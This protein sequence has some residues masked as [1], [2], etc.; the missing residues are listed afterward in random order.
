MTYTGGFGIRLNSKDIYCVFAENQS[1][2]GHQHGS[3]YSRLLKFLSK[4]DRLSVVIIIARATTAYSFLTLKLEL[5]LVDELSIFGKLI[6]VLDFRLCITEFHVIEP[7]FTCV[8]KV[9]Q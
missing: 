4:G 8:R 3:R 5:F 2:N 1:P 6:K 7:A 9:C